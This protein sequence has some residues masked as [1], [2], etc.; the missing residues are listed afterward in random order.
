MVDF[1]YIKNEMQ[2]RGISKFKT[3]PMVYTLNEPSALL[4][5]DRYIYLFVSTSISCPEFTKIEL[6][7]RDNYLVFT[8]TLLEKMDSAQYQFFT[9]E[10]E[11][12]ASQYGSDNIEDYKPIR[13]EFIKIIPIEYERKD[14]AGNGAA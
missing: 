12:E 1:E 13:L 3:M 11:I 10:L 7:S 4:D 14:G 8:K 6:K 9:E 2:N 5:L